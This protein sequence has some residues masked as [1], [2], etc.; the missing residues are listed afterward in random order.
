MFISARACSI[1]L[2]TSGLEYCDTGS[3]VWRFVVT[4]H[5]GRHRGV[6]PLAVAQ[7]DAVD[8]PLHVHG[9]VDRLP[10]APVR[11]RA[12]LDL[13]DAEVDDAA[14]RRLLDPDGLR[15]REILEL[16]RR[17][18]DDEVRLTRLEDRKAHV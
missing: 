6:D 13:G 17:D 7:E 14:A 10:H 12:A 5:I 2:S 1:S 11:E 9:V 3:P 15:G 18:V 4:P 8:D 16:V